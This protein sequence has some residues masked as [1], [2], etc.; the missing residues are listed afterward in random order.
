MFNI[1]I[2]KAEIYDNMSLNI[3]KSCG[4]Y[5]TGFSNYST[6]RISYKKKM[7]LFFSNLSKWEEELYEMTNWYQ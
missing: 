3:K 2:N 7:S 6:E 1:L 4:N 5:I